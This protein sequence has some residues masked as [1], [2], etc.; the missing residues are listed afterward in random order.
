M[1]VCAYIKDICILQSGIMKVWAAGTLA[2]WLQVGEVDMINN[3]SIIILLFYLIITWL[4][5]IGM[6]L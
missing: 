6:Y 5:V 4:Y 2:L 3:I 1:G